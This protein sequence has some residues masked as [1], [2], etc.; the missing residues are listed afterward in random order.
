MEKILH[1]IWKYF[2]ENLLQENKILG[3]ET[4]AVFKV[5][6]FSKNQ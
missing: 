1:Q 3:V 5:Q 4:K 6:R 2:K